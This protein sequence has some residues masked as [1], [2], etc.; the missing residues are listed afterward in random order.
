MI[1]FACVQSS[2]RILSSWADGAIWQREGLMKYEKFTCK[3]VDE[4]QAGTA[5]QVGSCEKCI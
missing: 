3:F 4:I 2:Q 1:G 5:R